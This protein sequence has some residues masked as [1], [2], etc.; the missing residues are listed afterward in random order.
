MPLK[1][2][3]PFK[4][5]T[6]ILKTISKDDMGNIDIAL[7]N[8]SFRFKEEEIIS[9]S[10]KSD[11]YSSL[12]QIKNSRT[13]N[14]RKWIWNRKWQF[15][16]TFI[17]LCGLINWFNYYEIFGTDYS[18]IP[19]YSESELINNQ[20]L[21][22]V[23]IC[24]IMFGL[25]LFFSLGYFWKLLQ[26]YL[27]IKYSPFFLDTDIFEIRL[28]SLTIQGRCSSLTSLKEI[29]NTLNIE[30]NKNMS[31][32]DVASKRELVALRSTFNYGDV[33]HLFRL[34]F[35]LLLFFFNA[36][37]PN[38]WYSIFS[39]KNELRDGAAFFPNWIQT[40]GENFG[41]SSVKYI[42]YFHGN[43]KGVFELLFDGIS[44][45]IGLLITI[46]IGIMFLILGIILVFTGC[47]WPI[48]TLLLFR[49]KINR[50][51][52]IGLFFLSLIHCIAFI[53]FINTIGE[54]PE[55]RFWMILNVSAMPTIFLIMFILGITI[56][57]FRRTRG[58]D[59]KIDIKAPK[60]MPQSIG[61]DLH[62]SAQVIKFEE[63][64]YSLEDL[65][66]NK[67]PI[68]SD[69]IP[70]FKLNHLFKF[71]YIDFNLINKL[72][73]GEGTP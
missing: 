46:S 26:R 5:K 28:H 40:Y 31:F 64:Y 13:P 73:D 65:R 14:L 25:P 67:I 52:F 32:G 45:G 69:E 59:N 53:Y 39:A 12:H 29:I 19:Y 20:S 42:S 15:I 61:I 44:S 2:T 10:L 60:N 8:K 70:H 3:W 62:H 21:R 43:E 11:F 16:L 66:K 27:I 34:V 71:Q 33:I 48:L 50:K 49:T 63:N 47:L 22:S 9:V 58:K 51:I 23:V 30:E 18:K 55:M 37:T 35:F 4:S 54:T 24:F 41:I 56:L 36:E 17:F 6:S 57:S 1:P 38:W 72:M 7:D 68:I